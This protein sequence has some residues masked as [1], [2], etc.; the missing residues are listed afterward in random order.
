MAPSSAPTPR[1]HHSHQTTPS[2]TSVTPATTINNDDKTIKQS[3]K[4]V[5]PLFFDVL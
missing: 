4:S 2:A 1:T 5:F 3:T